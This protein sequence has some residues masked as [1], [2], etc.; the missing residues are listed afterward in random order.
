MCA[1]HTGCCT[2][3]LSSKIFLKYF[4]IKSIP[5]ALHIKG[6]LIGARLLKLRMTLII[7]RKAIIVKRGV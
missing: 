1:Q 2:R 3:V 7:G 5:L 4:Q 6:K